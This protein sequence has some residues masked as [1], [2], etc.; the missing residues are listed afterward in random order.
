MSFNKQTK[1]NIHA[2]VWSK[3]TLKVR[4]A[5]TGALSSLYEGGGSFEEGCET[6]RQWADSVG[7]VWLDDD[8]DASFRRTKQYCLEVDRWEW[9]RLL[10][11]ALAG[12]VR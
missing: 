6:V 12:Y 4:K 5:F 3:T 1:Q 9:M 8:G 2:A 7:T 10:W 11:P